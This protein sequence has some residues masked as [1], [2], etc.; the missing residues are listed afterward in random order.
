MYEPGT[1]IL[2]N[3]SAMVRLRF[4]LSAVALFLLGDFWRVEPVLRVGE[5]AFRVGEAAPIFCGLLER[6]P[7]A[8]ILRR[9]RSD[10]LQEGFIIVNRE[11]IVTPG[12]VQVKSCQHFRNIAVMYQRFFHGKVSCISHKKLYPKPN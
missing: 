12:F 6:G 5:A 3:R 1:V 9:Y 2:A 7:I 4:V 8:L 11:N 10:P